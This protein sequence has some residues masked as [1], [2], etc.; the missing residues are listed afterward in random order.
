MKD[1]QD[2]LPWGRTGSAINVAMSGLLVLGVSTEG[3]SF[4][5]FGGI[6]LLALFIGVM[7][8]SWVRTRERASNR[9]EG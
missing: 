5:L 2:F 8:W 7:I 9:G 4:A 6:G 3:W 1:W